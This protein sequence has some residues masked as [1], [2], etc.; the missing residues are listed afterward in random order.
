MALNRWVIKFAPHFTPSSPWVRL[1]EECPRATFIP[2][3]VKPLIAAKA[4][5]S[6]GA[7]VTIIT[8]SKDP[9]T[10]RMDSKP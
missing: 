10:S 2:R 8:S 1:A 7:K 9:Y 6:S 4:P 3:F 5:G